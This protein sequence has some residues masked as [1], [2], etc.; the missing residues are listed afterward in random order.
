VKDDEEQPI[1]LAEFRD[2]IGESHHV[3]FHGALT[4]SKL[5]RSDRMTMKAAGA[6]EG[7]FRNWDAIAAWVDGIATSVRKTA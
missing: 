4:H 1:E 7:D 5:D 3:V 2:K 6:A